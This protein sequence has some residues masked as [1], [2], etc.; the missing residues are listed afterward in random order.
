MS[1]LQL[2]PNKL[3]KILKKDRISYNKLRLLKILTENKIQIKDKKKYN[4]NN[5]KLYYHTIKRYI[6]VITKLYKI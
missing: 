1:K 3:T 5:K 2:L 4:I 6:S